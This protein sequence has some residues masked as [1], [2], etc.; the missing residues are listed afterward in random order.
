MI[1]DV[2]IYTTPLST[3]ADKFQEQIDGI[4]QRVRDF[5]RSSMIHR[6][7]GIITEQTFLDENSLMVVA[8]CR[9]HK[10]G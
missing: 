7:A 8:R 3:Q 10:G 9:I 5:I 2:Q 4:M 1:I 6:S